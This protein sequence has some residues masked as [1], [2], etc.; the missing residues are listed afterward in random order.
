MRLESPIPTP[1]RRLPGVRPVCLLLVAVAL[2]N[3]FAAARTAL[4]VPQYMALGVTFPPLLT[5]AG[6]L[7][8]GVGFLWAA[9]RVWHVRNR[10]PRPVFLFVSAHGLYSL[11]WWR[12]YAVAD[13]ARARWPFAALATVTLV[14]LFVW[15]VYRL[16]RRALAQ[17]CLAPE[18]NSCPERP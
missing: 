15:V 4:L 11:I 12:V 1:S 9:W 8:W 6:S 10:S 14:V 17:E 2:T 5:A 13:Y 7:I 16:R 3:L 18:L